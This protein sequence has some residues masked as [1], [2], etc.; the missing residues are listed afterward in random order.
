[1]YAIIDE[2]QDEYLVDINA[3]TV[4]LENLINLNDDIRAIGGVSQNDVQLMQTYSE[5]M[6]ALESIQSTLP[7][8]RTFTQSP[9]LTNYNVATESLFD[10]IKAAFKW[11][12]DQIVGFFKWIGRVLASF[13]RWITGKTK[14]DE[15]VIAEVKTEDIQEAVFDPVEVVTQTNATAVT[16]ALPPPAPVE[17]VKAAVTSDLSGLV[18][19]GKRIESLAVVSTDIPGDTKEKI[20]TLQNYSKTALEIHKDLVKLD[21][22]LDA[23]SPKE[24]DTYNSL[25]DGITGYVDSIQAAIV[26][27]NA[28]G[29]RLD[30][31]DMDHLKRVSAEEIIVRSETYLAFQETLKADT[32]ALTKDEKQSE[33]NPTPAFA[34][35]TLRAYCPVDTYGKIESIVDSQKHTIELLG[36]ALNEYKEVLKGAVDKNMAFTS[37]PTPSLEYSAITIATRCASLGN[38]SVKVINFYKN[39]AKGKDTLSSVLSRNSSAIKQLENMQKDFQEAQVAINNMLNDPERTNT[40]E[41]LG[42]VLKSIENNF[43][44]TKLLPMRL[45][46]IAQVAHNSNKAA[47]T[48]VTSLEKQYG[49]SKK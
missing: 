36:K 23:L 35:A 42:D 21:I 18:E 1:M 34:E 38:N 46:D 7:D 8:L 44:V 13:W 37:V 12:F 49:K 22:D 25:V 17:E 31:L 41:R 26:S 5:G 24:K 29:P 6:V 16:E 40:K 45:R 14:D 4:A 28:M 19:I 15:K 39:Y 10:K 27:L 32:V 48:L 33:T 3:T 20:R 30:K 2:Q 43:N 11:L 9:S 47:R